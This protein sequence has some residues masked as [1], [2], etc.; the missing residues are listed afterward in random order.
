MSAVIITMAGESRRFREAGYAQ[1]KYRLEVKSRSLFTWAMLS[2]SAFVD[3]DWK[4]IL[5]ARSSDTELETFVQKE[6]AEL[7]WP[8]PR[9]VL[10]DEP[11][12]GQATTALKAKSFVDA[13]EPIVIYNI[14]THVTSGAM[15]PS[16]MN[17]DGWIPCFEAEGDSWSFVATDADGNVTEV[18]EKVR[19]SDHATV[20]LYGFSKFRYFEEAYLQ[21]GDR[22]GV[23]EASERYIAPL[24]NHLLRHGLNVHN[25]CLPAGSVIQLGTPADVEAFQ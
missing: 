18:R 6:F 4:V 19:I 20:G 17:G 8:S 7:G 24:Y 3:A 2:V 15:S 13:D 23:A 16:E 25:F 5:V 9:I 1:P 10:L 12:D 14:D 21:T 22:V 11:T